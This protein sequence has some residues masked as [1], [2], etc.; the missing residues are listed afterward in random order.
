MR[1]GL[2]PLA[3]GMAR[4]D[5]QAGRGFWRSQNKNVGCNLQLHRTTSTFGALAQ[6][7]PVKIA[8][9]KL[10]AASGYADKRLNYHD[11]I[12]AKAG[13]HVDFQRPNGFPLSRE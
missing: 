13:I 11:V 1:S 4:L 8:P 2:A 9:Y 3:R 12:P 6:G 5:K 7:Q 10:G